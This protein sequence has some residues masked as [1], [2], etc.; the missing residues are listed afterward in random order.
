MYNAGRSH[1]NTIRFETFK[2]GPYEDP[3]DVILSREAIFV[4]TFI[5]NRTILEIVNEYEAHF[6]TVKKKPNLR[7]GYQF[8]KELYRYCVDVNFH[9]DIGLLI[10]GGCLEEGCWPMYCSMKETENTVVWSDFCNPHLSGEFGGKPDVDYSRLGPFEFE[11]DQF[12]SEVEKLRESAEEDRIVAQKCH[13]KWLA[14]MAE[15]TETQKAAAQ[16]FSGN[17]C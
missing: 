7:Y 15:V 2:M 16:S 3:D 9:S 17:S 10:C 12:W 14:E 6:F 5:D 1:I 11:K 13:E 4:K 8:V